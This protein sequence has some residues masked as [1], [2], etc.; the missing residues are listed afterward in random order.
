MATEG[1][2][3]SVVDADAGMHCQL[4]WVVKMVSSDIRMQCFSQ[5]YPDPSENLLLSLRSISKHL[6]SWTTLISLKQAAALN[7]GC[8]PYLLIPH[9]VSWVVITSII[10]RVARAPG[11]LAASLQS[12][13]SLVIICEV[14]LYVL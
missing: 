1:V 12:S 10:P 13:C 5:S 4:I 11:N 7:T 14:P 2:L 9:Y 3:G 8:A 6:P